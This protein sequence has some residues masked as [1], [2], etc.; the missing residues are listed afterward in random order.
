MRE[1][2]DA[3]R[4]LERLARLKASGALSDAEFQRMKAGVLGNPD[5][6]RRSANRR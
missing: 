6:I 3:K 5:D 1:Y 4:A 2:S